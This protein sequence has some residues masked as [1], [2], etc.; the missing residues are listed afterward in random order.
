MELEVWKEFEMYGRGWAVSSFGRIKMLWRITKTGMKSLT[1]G[2]PLKPFR[3]DRGYLV[4]KVTLKDESGKKKSKRPTIHRLVCTAF[5]ENPENKPQVNHKDGNQ[6]NNH[7]DNLEWAT[8]K[9]N[10]QHAWATGLCKRKYNITEE[11]IAV[12]KDNYAEVGCWDLEEKLGLPAKIIAK[13]ANKMGL[14]M[15]KVFSKKVI[16][17]NTNKIYN[18][19]QEVANEFGI[20]MRDIRRRLANERQNRTSFRYID[21][22]GKVIPAKVFPTVPKYIPPR[23]IKPIA[24]FDM[25]WNELKR[26]QYIGDAALFV[27]GDNGSINDF[28]NGKQE[29]HKGYKFKL[30][31]ENGNYIEPIPFV[32][33]RKPKIIKIKGEVSPSKSVEKYNTEGELLGIYESIGIAA[34]SIGADKK[35][36]RRQIGK[37]PT[38]YARGY[39]WKVI[40]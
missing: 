38:G 9:E 30:I 32:T 3:N 4:I 11:Q 24:V 31:D 8:A 16:D 17:L 13:V 23:P 39:T 2:E 7:K 36:F 33:K 10:T 20:N 34:K 1:R 12:I 15:T 22:D 19:C 37:S 40:G 26:F 28:L 18:S 27:G 29:Q 21:K 14:K 25:E 5:H 6:L 35:Q